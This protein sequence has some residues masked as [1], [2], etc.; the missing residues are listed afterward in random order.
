[1]NN[2]LKEQETDRLLIR[3]LTLTDNVIWTKFLSDPDCTE[4]FP[5]YMRNDSKS[6]A[7]TWIQKQLERY[8]ENRFGLLGL[9]EKSTGKFI[10]Q[11]GLL[12]QEI[13]GSP[14]IEIGYH[15][16]PEFH[17]KGYASEAAKHFKQYAFDKNIT[18]S[19][20]SIIHRDNIAS[21]KVAQRNGMTNSKSTTF[22]DIDVFIFRINK[23]EYL[24]DNF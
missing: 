22:H 11:C 24:K 15:L 10:G 2:Y 20:I 17:G 4:F 9:I 5:K 1:M 8:E 12:T 21:Q 18:E 16:L 14:E 7:I 23:E 3:P 19:I 6:R 13:D